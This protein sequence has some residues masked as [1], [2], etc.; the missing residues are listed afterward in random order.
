MKLLKKSR[1]FLVLEAGPRS[2]SQSSVIDFSLTP[3]YLYKGNNILI[4]AYFLEIDSN[5]NNL[6]CSP[7]NFDNFL[8]H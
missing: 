2:C 5:A 6:V 4:V 8:F 1:N 3:R 7:E